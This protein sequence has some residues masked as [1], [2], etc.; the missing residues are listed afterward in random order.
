MSQRDDYEP[1]VPCWVDTL[2]PDPEAAMAFY[3]ALFGWEFA[4]PG[5]MGYSVARLRGRDVAGVGSQPPQAQRRR[6]A[7]PPTCTSR[8]PTRPPSRSAAP[9]APS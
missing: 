2:Q 4:G 3:G 9:A 5:P 7:G 8:A 1:G 6:R